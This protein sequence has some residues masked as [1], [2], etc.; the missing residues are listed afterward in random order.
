MKCRN[1]ETHWKL[2]RQ[3]RYD[4][5]VL[6]ITVAVECK[7]KLLVLDVI[8]CRTKQF[9]DAKKYSVKEQQKVNVT[10]SSVGGRADN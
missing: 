7:H 1:R 3:S 10:K 8:S 2:L 9:S 6:L 4:K 5:V